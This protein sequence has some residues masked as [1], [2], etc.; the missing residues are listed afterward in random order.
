[1]DGHSNQYL[2]GFAGG[3][4]TKYDNLTSAR[5]RCAAL[6]ALCTGV[7]WSSSQR[8]DANGFPVG[9]FTVRGGVH[10]QGSALGEITWLKSEGGVDNATD[11][12][13]AGIFGRGGAGMEKGE[14]NQAF[15][16]TAINGFGGTFLMGFA[17]GTH[18]ILTLV[19]TSW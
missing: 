13:K 14:A 11:L 1:V 4:E 17:G 18:T 7:T 9:L 12:P 6:G 8:W 16:D 19:Q 15:Q 10:L 3:D 5:V 2:Y